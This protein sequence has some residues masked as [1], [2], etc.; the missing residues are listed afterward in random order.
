MS[1]TSVGETEVGGIQTGGERESSL[2][3]GLR[4]QVSPDFQLR[5]QQPG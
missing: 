4:S 2:S 3:N 1:L 5:C